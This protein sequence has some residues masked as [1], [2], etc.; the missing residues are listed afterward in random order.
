MLSDYFAAIASLEPGRIASCFRAD[1]ELE[2]PVGS[3]VRSGHD[4]IRDYWSLGL[5]AVAAVVEIEIVAALPA[6]DSIAGHWQMKARS[7][8]GAVAH[9][10]GIDVLRL[11]EDG[12]IRRAEGYWDLA[13]F[14][15][16]LT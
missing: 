3:L 14:R 1:G 7:H 13:A 12:L 5:C 4:E 6:G 10:E 8:N 11:D 9:A 2:D 15:H 16:A